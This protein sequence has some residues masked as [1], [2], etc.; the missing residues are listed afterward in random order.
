VVILFCNVAPFPSGFIVNIFPCHAK[1]WTKRAISRV[2]SVPGQ[3]IAVPA[4][5]PAGIGPG[6][7][8]L[9]SSSNSACDIFI[10]SRISIRFLALMSLAFGRVRL[11]RT[12]IDEKSDE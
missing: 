3:T 11:R 9:N 7:L 10:S 12:L 8:F 6:G 2:H 5:L 1:S 4:A